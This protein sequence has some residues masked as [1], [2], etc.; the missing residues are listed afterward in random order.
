[1]ITNV[2]FYRVLRLYKWSSIISPS[3]CILVLFS[4]IEAHFF[5]KLN[6]QMQQ[7]I[8]GTDNLEL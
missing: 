2:F 5:A 3:G 8:Q 6:K 4:N 7:V 1:M